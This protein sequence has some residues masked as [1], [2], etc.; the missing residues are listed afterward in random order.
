MSVV[1]DGAGSIDIGAF[2]VGAGPAFYAFQQSDQSI[3]TG[4]YTKVT[5]GGELFDTD[6]CFSSSRFTPNV[7]GYYQ[8]NAL[9]RVSANAGTLTSVI[10]TIYKNG[11]LY[12]VFPNFVVNITTAYAAYSSVVYL[13]GTTDYVELWGQA[14]GTSPLFDYSSDLNGCRFSGFLVR[15]A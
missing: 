1:I 11:T 4:T 6:N 8:I 3:T 12:D 14:S 5:L 7:A 2:P 13:N 9:I 10:A 15:A